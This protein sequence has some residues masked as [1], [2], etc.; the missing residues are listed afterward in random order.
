V[1]MVDLSP[2][3]RY[4]QT[5]MKKRLVPTEKIEN[6]KAP[7]I[8]RATR[9]LDWSHHLTFM[10]LI[11]ALFPSIS[12]ACW[13]LCI[14]VQVCNHVHDVH[15]KEVLK[16][17]PSCCFL[18]S[19]DRSPDRAFFK[20]YWESVPGE[21]LREQENLRKL[22]DLKG[23]PR[24][25]GFGTHLLLKKEILILEPVGK[26]LANV[27]ITEAE[28]SSICEEFCG[29]V[30]A[31]HERGL[32]HNDIKPEHILLLEGK[33]VLLIDFG[34]ASEIGAPIY[35]L[36]LTPQFCHPDLRSGKIL[37]S[38]YTDWYSVVQTFSAIVEYFGLN[39]SHV[40]CLNIITRYQRMEDGDLTQ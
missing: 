18:G 14:P 30:H 37:T 13:S 24:I 16:L 32:V 19:M 6:I 40:K 26:K 23:V 9:R 38:K 17:A 15:V 8:V 36:R 10:F 2:E 39:A 31:I 27:S 28:L 3:L 5:E 1:V 33:H 7:Y 35:G 11:F 12:S 25:L 29:I 21:L 20:F 4:V 22:C 34:S